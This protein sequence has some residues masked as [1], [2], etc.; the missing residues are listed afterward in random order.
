MRYYLI[1]VCKHDAR[2]EIT[3]ELAK[4]ITGDREPDMK[5]KIASYCSAVHRWVVDKNAG[6][7]IDGYVK[8]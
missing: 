1:N 7:V 3:E 6:F 8:E 2:V 5:V 4:H